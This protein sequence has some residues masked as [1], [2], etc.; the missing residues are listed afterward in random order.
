MAKGNRKRTKKQKKNKI[1]P[2]LI[3]IS[4]DG[5]KIKRY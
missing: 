2:E 4:L 3:T 1:E 5:K